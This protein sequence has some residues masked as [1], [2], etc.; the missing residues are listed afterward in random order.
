MT[1][2]LTDSVSETFE[3]LREMVAGMPR[4]T[5]GRARAA[6]MH[7]ETA[8]QEL[9]RDHARD[10]AV[11]LGAAFAIFVIAQRVIDMDSQSDSADKSLIQL[12]N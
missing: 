6:A 12:L 7:I 10:P 5:K 8:W 9:R 11:A 2:L 1:Q 4:E 3:N